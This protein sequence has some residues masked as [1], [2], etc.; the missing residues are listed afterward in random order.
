MAPKILIVLS[1]LNWFFFLF[2]HYKNEQLMAQ[3]KLTRQNMTNITKE[4]IKGICDSVGDIFTES[5]NIGLRSTS[6][7]IDNDEN[8]DRKTWFGPRSQNARLMYHLERK[9]QNAQTD[10]FT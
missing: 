7:L 3:I 9:I 1:R 8:H 2:E 5:E 6:M 10:S 4:N